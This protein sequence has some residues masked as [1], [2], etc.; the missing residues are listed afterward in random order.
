MRSTRSARPSRGAILLTWPWRRAETAPGTQS[1]RGILSP[2]AEGWHPGVIRT[3]SPGASR[4][5][6]NRLTHR[7]R[8]GAGLGPVAQ[9]VGRSVTGVNIG[10]AITMAAPRK[11][12]HPLWRWAR[13]WRAVSARSPNR[14]RPCRRD[15]WFCAHGAIFGRAA[16][17]RWN[18]GLMPLL[19]RGPPMSGPVD[20]VAQNRLLFGIGSPEP[21]LLGICNPVMSRASGRWRQSVRFIA[22]D[23]GGTPRMH[24]LGAP[25]TRRLA[26]SANWCPRASHGKL[27][28]TS[29]MGAP[30]F[31]WTCRRSCRIEQSAF[32][33]AS[34]RLPSPETS[35]YI[36]HSP[37][38]SQKKSLES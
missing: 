36:R 12:H 25:P 27:R 29:G 4:N 9:G 26:S 38:G 16:R 31:S 35:R 18:S 8:L 22:K 33:A 15:G 14:S 30:G 21:R 28:P 37:T 6:I 17:R 20:Q 10:D 23:A 24:R 7:H 2:A 1:R 34:R 5:A 19:A 11:G 3:S 13:E 32:V